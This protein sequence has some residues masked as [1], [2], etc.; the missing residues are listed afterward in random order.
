MQLIAQLALKMNINKLINFYF[1]M[2][3]LTFLDIYDFNFPSQVTEFHIQ[4]RNII[5]LKYL[6]AQYIFKIIF[7]LENHNFIKSFEN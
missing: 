6:K 7:G 2:Q 3:F 4:F 5:D 1:L